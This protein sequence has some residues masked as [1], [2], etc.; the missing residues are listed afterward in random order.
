MKRTSSTI[1]EKIWRK[2]IMLTILLFV[3][4]MVSACSGINIDAAKTLGKTGRTVVVQAQQNIMVSDKE[5]SCAMDS[6]YFMH[7]Y[8]GTTQLPQYLQILDSYNDVQQELAKRSVV[9]EKL[10]DLYDAF[11]GLAGLDTGTETE[12]ALGD[13]GGAITSYAKQINK[14]TALLSDATGVISKIGGIIM[15]EIQKNKI[16]EASIQIRQ[17][18]DAFEQLLG[19]PTVRNQTIGFRNLLAADR[20]S[21]F[22]TL[23][24]SGVYDPKSLLDNFGMDAGLVSKNNVSDLIKSTPDSGKALNNGLKEVIVKRLSRNDLVLIEKSYDTSLTA[25]KNLVVEHKKLE[26]GEPLDL[27]RLQANIAEL[28]GIVVLLGKVKN[29]ISANK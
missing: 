1:A 10:A 28:Q 12:K 22:T 6:E 18:V 13:L 9:F 14:P 7:G 24:D 25:L 16:K 20:N 11:G 8:G 27:A 19:S 26:Q 17:R 4:F 15:T 5:Y 21:A 3:V 2:I 29:D 23:W